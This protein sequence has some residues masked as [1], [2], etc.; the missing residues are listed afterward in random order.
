MSSVEGCKSSPAEGDSA[1][2]PATSLL[3]SITIEFGFRQCIRFWHPLGVALEA[4]P[5][6]ALLGNDTGMTP[7]A[8][9]SALFG[10][11]SPRSREVDHR[12]DRCW[13]LESRHPQVHSCWRMLEYVGA[14]WMKHR[15][16]GGML[17][18]PPSVQIAPPKIIPPFSKTNRKPN[19]PPSLNGTC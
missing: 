10:I 1:F 6:N 14:V 5:L 11:C 19:H 9:C 12:E 13:A 3:R 15:V 16:H 8:L 2:D 17:T 7:I 18:E 4:R